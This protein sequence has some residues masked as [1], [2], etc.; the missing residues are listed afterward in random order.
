MYMKTFYKVKP[1]HKY[2]YKPIKRIYNHLNPE[3]DEIIKSKKAPCITKKG[4]E[5][6]GDVRVFKCTR[7]EIV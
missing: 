5:L 4:I 1:S 7:E 3:L 2:A 6:L